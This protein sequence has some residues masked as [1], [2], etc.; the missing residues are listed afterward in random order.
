MKYFIFYTALISIAV[1][2]NVKKHPIDVDIGELIKTLNGLLSLSDEYH[3]Q[4]KRQFAGLRPS[5]D[6]NEPDNSSFVLRNQF[7]I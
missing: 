6:F 2:A 3:M 1:S 7:L 5:L 4:N